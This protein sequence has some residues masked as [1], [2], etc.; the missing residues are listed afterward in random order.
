MASKEINYNGHTFT[1]SYEQLNPSQEEVLLVLHGWGSNKEIMKQAFGKLLP[2]YRHIYLDMPGFGKSSNDTVLTTEDYAA[3]V[4]L[5]LET[6]GVS[7]K[8]AMGHSFGGKVSTL[9]NPPCLVLLS[10]SGI[11]VPKPLGVRMKIALTKLLRPL[12]FAKLGRLFASKDVE[13]MSHEMYETFKNVVNETFEHHFSKV[14]GKALL[15]WGKAD[16][17]TPLW[18]AE[19]IEKLIPDAT[20]Y[21]LDGDH[22]F[23]LS[24]A[25]LIAQTIQDHCKE[26]R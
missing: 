15:F 6:L 20:L 19:K 18:T 1:L 8:I 7:P 13:G 2:E 9:L 23:F 21:P 17:A 22:F 12:G 4:R 26:T 10:S 25:P 14:N 24:H 16:T 5:F 11:L 3:I